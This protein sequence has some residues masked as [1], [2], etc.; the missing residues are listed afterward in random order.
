MNMK[1]ISMGS[2]FS[3]FRL[4]RPP[5]ALTSHLLVALLLVVW[6]SA[7]VVAAGLFVIFVPLRIFLIRSSIRLFMKDSQHDDSSVFLSL[8]PTLIF[9]LVIAGIL[10][11]RGILAKHLIYALIIYTLLTSLLPSI[12]FV[13][14]AKIKLK[15][16]KNRH[17]ESE[18]S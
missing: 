9:G 14:K 8:M 12:V 11:E 10:F 18:G 7:L 17:Q 6:R 2:P 5:I 16:F 4:L 1:A 3:A 15:L 13:L